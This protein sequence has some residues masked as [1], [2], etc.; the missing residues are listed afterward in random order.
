M[1]TTDF[2]SVARRAAREAGS[3]LLDEF[4]GALAPGIKDDG[5]LQAAA[6]MS[7]HQTLVSVLT[8]MVPEHGIISEESE[9]E[10]GSVESSYKWI[11]DPLE[12]TSNFSI[13]MSH[14]GVSLA[15]VRDEKLL[16][17]AVYLPI[18]DEMFVAELGQGAFRNDT[19][20]QV[21]EETKLDKVTITLGRGRLGGGI[22]RHTKIFSSLV[23]AV[24]SSRMYGATALD[25]CLV[26]S[27]GSGAHINNDCKFYDGASGALIA[28]EAGA[29]VTDFSG[30]PWKPELTGY[31]DL[32]IA[33]KA[34]HTQLLALLQGL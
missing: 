11:L 5:S 16:V 18:T 34:M 29:I 7:A 4:G 21:T 33:P 14:W 25:I 24:R 20:L 30:Q 3:V 23:P 19:R 17:G 8:E 2:L 28:A 15:L 26:A 9:E 27:G 13:G 1:V 12:G 22:P 31:A 10:L 6:D 32:L